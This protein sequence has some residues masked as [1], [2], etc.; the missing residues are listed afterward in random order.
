MA[1]FPEMLLFGMPIDLRTM[2]STL[3]GSLC[4]RARKTMYVGSGRHDFGN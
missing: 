2:P 3:F 1:D 4:Y